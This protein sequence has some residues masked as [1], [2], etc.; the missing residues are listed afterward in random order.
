MFRTLNGG[1]GGKGPTDTG[2]H[3]RGRLEGAMVAA[4]SLHGYGETTVGELVGLAGVSK[5]TFYEH[6][7]SKEACYF[8]TF[9]TIVDEVIARVGIAYRSESGLRERLAASMARFAEI[10]TEESAAASLVVVDSLSLGPVAVGHRERAAGAFEEMFRQSFERSEGADE[11][12]SPLAV[13][14]IVAGIRRVVYRRLRADRPEEVSEHLDDLLDWA[15]SYRGQVAPTS[16]PPRRARA[17]PA[18]SPTSE[19]IDWEEPADSPRSRAGQTQRE[20]IVRA[21][22]QVA[23]AKGYASLT[24]PSISAA[25]GTSNQTFY[26]HFDGKEQA[27]LAAF[28]ELAGRALLATRSGSSA[29]RDWRTSVEDGML[30]LL[31]HLV[32]DR[33]FARLAFFELPTAGAAALERADLAV[34]RFTEF[35]EPKALPDRLTPLPPVVV[36]AIGGGMWA[37]IQHEIAAGRLSSLP[38]KAPE[39]AAIALT[40]FDSR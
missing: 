7:D 4:V 30:G 34:Q 21:A 6:F 25:S 36:E 29:G 19:E 31:E 5:S 33:N 1:R 26:E 20:R 24:I 9:E 35:L 39:I 11:A 32:A 22:A 14:A 10:L 27:F 17:V 8:A 12:P 16:V 18:S 2:R 38:E 13:R 23:G 37:V 40:P 28:D 15:L 3:Q